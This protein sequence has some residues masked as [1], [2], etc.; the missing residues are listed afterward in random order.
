MPQ[1]WSNGDWTTLEQIAV[2]AFDLYPRLHVASSGL[3]WMTSLVQTWTLDVSEGG[4]WTPVPNVLRLNGLR[5]YAPSVLYDVD[6]VIFIG[7]GNPPTGNAETIDLG[8]AQPAWKATGAMNFPRRQHN[9]TILPDGTVLVTGGT[10]GGGAPGTPEGFNDLDPGQP[11]HMAELWDPAT[12]QW[13]ELAAEKMDRCYHSTAV[14]LPDATVLS[15]GSGE[16]FPVEA[17]TQENDPQDSHR[18]AQVFSPPYLFKGPRP[19]ITSAPAS[20]HY[21][22]EFEVG[23]R[24]AGRYRARQLDSPVLRD[25]LVQH[26]PALQLPLVPPAAGG[27]AVTAPASP[28]VC[29]PGHYM[30]FILNQQGVP[31]TATMVEIAAPAAAAAAAAGGIQPGS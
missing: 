31:S 6:K 11:V 9:A 18:D 23:T 7:G 22:D 14:L 8:Q 24:P 10:R 17:I 26:E 28:N 1:V 12:G 16:F 3:V 29:P 30:L 21:G 4:Q 25:P 5:D 19:A 13:T 2:G 27:L 20:V 15:A